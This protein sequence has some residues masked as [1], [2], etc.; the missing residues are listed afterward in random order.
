MT[1]VP[2]CGLEAVVLVAWKWHLQSIQPC[3]ALCPATSL[4]APVQEPCMLFEYTAEM[5]SCTLVAEMLSCVLVAEMLVV[6]N[7]M[8]D[9]IT[10]V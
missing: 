5:L 6:L 2:C 8:P 1:D 4:H 9:N 10:N 3:A 7:D